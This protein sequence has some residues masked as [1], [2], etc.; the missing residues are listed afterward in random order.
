[1]KEKF[2]NEDIFEELEKMTN[3]AKDFNN[4]MDLYCEFMK[5]VFLSGSCLN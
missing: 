1:M 2:D 5:K 4:K 3:E